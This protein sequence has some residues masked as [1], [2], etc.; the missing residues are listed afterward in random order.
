MEGPAYIAVLV[1]GGSSYSTAAEDISGVLSPGTV[2]SASQG[3]NHES[4]MHAMK[5]CASI[6]VFN[7]RHELLGV[8]D[9]CFDVDQSIPTSQHLCVE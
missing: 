2:H 7:A 8:L 9:G 1:V 5:T 6:M 4:D 3:V